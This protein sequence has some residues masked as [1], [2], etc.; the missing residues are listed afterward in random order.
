MWN[1]KAFTENELSRFAKAALVILLVIPVIFITIQNIIKGEVHHP[2]AFIICLV[3]FALFLISKISTISNGKWISF[4]T[5]KL[6]EN[7][8]NLYRIGYWLMAVGLIFTFI[9]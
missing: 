5:K 8:A 6:T 3:G 2:Y 9:K 7:T 1:N 4:G